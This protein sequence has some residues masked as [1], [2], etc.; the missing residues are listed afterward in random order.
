MIYTGKE[1]RKGRLDDELEMEDVFVV[2]TSVMIDD[3]D[4]FFNLGR[5]WIVVP[6]AVIR[7]LDGLKRSTDSKKACAAKRASRTLDDLGYHQDIAFGALT[8][9]GSIVR[10]FGGY[11]TVNDLESWADNRIVGAAV[12]L[13]EENKH[14]NVVMVS[15]DRNMCTITRA[16][17]IEAEHYPFS[18][19]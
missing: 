19:N 13:K 16:Y 17:G 6:T 2:D 18:R 12:R 15:N 9:A 10:I 4:V 3:P 11:E 5:K 14:Y 7:E 1:R 8:S